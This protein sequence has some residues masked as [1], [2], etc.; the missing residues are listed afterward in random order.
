MMIVAMYGGFYAGLLGMVISGL[1][2]LFWIQKGYLS[3]VET[4]AFVVFIISCL[5]IS[6]IAEAMKRARRQAKEAQE[7]AEIANKAKSMFLAN[8]SHELRTPL[9]AILGYSHLMQREEDLGSRSQE[10]LQ[11]INRSGEHLLSLINEVLEIAKIEA[12]RVI[13]DPGTFNIHTTIEEVGKMF[14]EKTQQ[15]G[16]LFEV[17]GAESLPGFVV[18][19]ET[20]LRIILINL[21]GNAVKFT[22]SGKISIRFATQKITAEEIFLHVEVEDTGPGIAPSDMDK[23]FHYF[24]QT[25]TGRTSQSGTGL[26]L[27]ISRDYVRMMGGE[28]S[29]SSRLGEGSTFTFTIRLDL[30]NEANIHGVAE[31]KRVKSLKPGSA[32]PRILV[33]EDSEINRNLMVTLLKGVGFDVQSAENGKEAVEIH[34]RWNPDFIW[35]DIRMPVMDGKEAAKIIKSSEGGASTII[36]ALS[37]HV[38]G[39]E[40]DD[41]LMA[42]CDDYVGKPFRENEI[43]EVMAKHLGLEYIYSDDTSNIEGTRTDSAVSLDF[44]ILDA[45][46]LEELKVAVNTTNAVQIALLAGRL[47]LQHPGIAAAL[48]NC[49]DNFDYESIQSALQIAMKPPVS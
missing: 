43:F 47:K 23:L 41:I 40:R 3:H 27:A 33:A 48:Q 5:M 14:W 15:K 42:G 19:D 2:S 17:S 18:G 16:L 39:Q 1:L 44:S 46:F 31:V 49:A 24:T 9:N 13:L 34:S 4:L 20:K 38:L 35:M 45:I 29:A 25:D 21:L 6:V 22:Q 8:M 26:G 7:Q 37:A 12:G 28:I 32:V 30:G 36:A 10:Y 11:I